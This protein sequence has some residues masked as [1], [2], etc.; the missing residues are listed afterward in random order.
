M[1]TLDYNGFQLQTTTIVTETTTLFSAPQTNVQIDQ[2]AHADGGRIVQQFM[3]SKS[4]T[5]T[6]TIYGG[7]VGGMQAAIDTFKAAMSQPNGI[8]TYAT[9]T[10]PAR[11]IYC[12]ASQV[13]IQNDTGLSNAQFTVQFESAD[14]TSW[15]T[16]LYSNTLML[17]AKGVTTASSSY[18]VNVLGSYK[19]QPD[20]F[21]TLASLSG[22]VN[23]SISITNGATL[24]GMTVTR[25]WAVGDTL[26]IDSLNMLVYVN[27]APVD[28]IGQFIEMTPGPNSLRYVDTFTARSVSITA[29][30]TK[31]WK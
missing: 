31:R 23:Q 19:A 12:T 15:D 10:Q 27:S 28:F 20:I 9:D 30:Y 4:F 25:T 11:I 8:L 13:G 6:G 18:P 14:G 16:G 2:L 26:E 3:A 7:T 24:R 17:S 5:I 21:V 22:G 1:I 29:T